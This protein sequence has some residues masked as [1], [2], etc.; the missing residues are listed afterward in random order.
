M[1]DILQNVVLRE[2]FGISASVF[3]LV[4]MMLKSDSRIGNIR[5]RVL[6]F[7]GSVL[8][9]LYGIWIYSISTVFLNIICLGT[10]IHYLNKL[11]KKKD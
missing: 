11:F 6:N 9:I 3:V 5:M 2:I 8:M 4:S 10:H 7:V 1:S